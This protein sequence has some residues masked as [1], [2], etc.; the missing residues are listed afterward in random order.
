MGKR[1]VNEAT[2]AEM[3]KVLSEIQNGEFA[4]AWILENMAGRPVFN[5]KRRQETEHPMVGVG[6]K[7]RSMMSWLP[8]QEGFDA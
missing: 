8:N 7:L 5:A 1:I 4:K 2:R 6:K 3:K